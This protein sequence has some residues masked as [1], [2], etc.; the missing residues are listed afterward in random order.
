MK[1]LINTKREYLEI[2]SK[3]IYAKSAMTK[4]DIKS[5]MTFQLSPGNSDMRN[6]YP[7]IPGKFRGTFR[8]FR[9]VTIF[10]EISGDFWSSQLSWKIP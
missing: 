4:N 3:H 9:K 2:V 6:D 8:I 1:W 5:K 10:L 7:R